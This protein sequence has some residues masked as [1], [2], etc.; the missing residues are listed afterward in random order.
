MKHVVKYLN[1]ITLLSFLYLTF[2]FIYA[3]PIQRIGFY[4]FFIAYLL[5]IIAEKKWEKVVFDTKTLYFIVLAV[6]FLLAI[7]Y[8]PFETSR[9]YTF[10]LLE[11]R[12]PLFGFAVVGFFGVNEKFKLNYFLNTFIVS[13]IIAIGYLLFYRIGIQEFIT[14]PARVE[15]FTFKRV[16]FVNTHMVFNFYLNVS[17]IGIWYILTRSWGRINWFKRYLYFGALTIILGTLSISEGRSG[18]VIAILLMLSFL[19]FEMLKRKKVIGIV[20]GLLIPFLLIGIASHHKRISQEK[21]K[22]EAR[23]FLWH[24]AI[25]VIEE[26]SLFGNGI[27][28]AQERFDVARTKYQTEEFRLYSVQFNHLDCHDQYLQTTMEFGIFGLFLLLFLYI[29][30]LFIVSFN[31]RLFT[32]FLLFLCAYQSIFDMFITGPFCPFFCLLILLMLSVRNNIVKPH[33]EVSN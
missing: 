26:S 23:I 13:S 20:I 32:F 31:K 15:L 1:Y 11:K 3:Y 25:A 4:V 22:T 29:Y 18:F 5:E 2:C 8:I 17:L 10:Y 27:S 16:E 28:D 33:Q 30:P 7:I 21:F 24:S 9:K 14:N 19:F 6:F 12:L